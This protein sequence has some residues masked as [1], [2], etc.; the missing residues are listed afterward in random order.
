MASRSPPFCS[1]PRFK[2]S[3]HILAVSRA[4]RGHKLS[5]P[6]TKPN[7]FSPHL[8]LLAD[9]LTLHH[10]TPQPGSNPQDS[11]PLSPNAYLPQHYHQLS[12]FVY[13]KT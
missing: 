4:Y 3:D 1:C 9:F 13:V 6:K 12:R 11:H 2:S 5:M 7:T 8:S 10:P